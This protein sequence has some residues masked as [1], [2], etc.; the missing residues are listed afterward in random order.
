MNKIHE[1][2][3]RICR[4]QS[5]FTQIEA[6]KLLNISNRSLVDYENWDREPSQQVVKRMV[7]LYNSEWLGWWYLKNISAVGKKLIPDISQELDNN[8]DIFTVFYIIDEAID[9]MIQTKQLLK[10]L[11]NDNTINEKDVLEYA[12]LRNLIH[13]T[14]GR[15]MGIYT[16]EPKV[17]RKK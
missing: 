12:K 10:K 9:K 11:V 8:E 3:Y 5:G 4:K 16:F 1:N 17:K 14:A 15:L 6:A 2:Y 7:E 13:G